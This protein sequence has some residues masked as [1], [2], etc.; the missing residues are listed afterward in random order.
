MDAHNLAAFV[1]LVQEDV[2]W[3]DEFPI[4]ECFNADTEDLALVDR[5][6]VRIL[7]F[8]GCDSGTCAVEAFLIVCELF[9]GE[10]EDGLV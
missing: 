6:G 3:P 9:L 7:D 8:E 2:V 1:W 5:E 4:C 10:V